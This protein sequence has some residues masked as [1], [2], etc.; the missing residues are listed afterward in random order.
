ML[1]LSPLHHKLM[2]LSDS[3]LSDPFRMEIAAVQEQLRLSAHQL[4]TPL[5]AL[6][7]AR[8]Q[9]TFPPIWAAVV[10]A[11]A[12]EEPDAALLEQRRLSLASALQTLFVALDIH[13]T[14]LRAPQHDGQRQD[15]TIIGG[16]ILAGDFYFSQAAGMAAQTDSPKVVTIFA[17]TLKKLSE[18]NLRW[19]HGVGPHHFDQTEALIEAGI[20]AASSLVSI[21]PVEQQQITQRGH[22]L[23][24]LYTGTQ[25]DAP[26][27]DLF[28]PDPP[29]NSRSQRW[30]ELTRWVAQSSN[31][32][33]KG[34]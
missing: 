16:T 26:P 24:R 18:A 4:E 32:F 20:L 31:Q 13:K 8:A 10:L 29:A 22:L 34:P 12:L 1:E 3:P 7:W 27:P 2:A 14:L 17:Q 21:P 5:N 23:A 33:Q 9:Q 11:T 15:K 30:Q 19:L 28:P 25:H 6:V